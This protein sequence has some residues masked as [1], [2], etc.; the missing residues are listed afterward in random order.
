MRDFPLAAKLVAWLMTLALAVFS[1]A[2]KFWSWLTA[3]FPFIVLLA[4]VSQRLEAK[5]TKGNVKTI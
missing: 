2:R 4:E 3:R 5:E 1:Y